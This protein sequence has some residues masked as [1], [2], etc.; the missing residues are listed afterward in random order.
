MIGKIISAAAF[1]ALLTFPV[2]ARAQVPWKTGE[3]LQFDIS[4]GFLA[5]GKA[6]LTVS[7]IFDHETSTNGI[8]QK[9]QAYRFLATAESNSFVDVFFKVRDKNESWL[10]VNGLFTHRFEQRNNE[11]KYHLN[12]VVEYDWIR[13]RFMQTDLV[14]GRAPKIEEGD[15]PNP[16]IDTLSS[17]YLVRT[18]DLKVG[19]DFSIDVHSG[20]IYPMIVKVLK[21]ETVKVPA[22]KFDCFVVEPFLKE[23]GIFIQKGKKLQV[24]L[25]ADDKK[26][27][28]KMQAE[29]FIGHVKAELAN[30]GQ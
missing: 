16:V 10:D 29:I 19:E 13:K 3:K 4:V 26:M 12:Q 8:T 24:W 7:D 11:G 5:A 21:R 18:K 1:T 9:Y 27:P 28:V 30:A 20:R 22:G 14:E 2:R 15:L 23:K 6:S 25:T 17:L